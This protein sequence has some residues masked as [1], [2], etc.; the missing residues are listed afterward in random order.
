M[1]DVLDPRRAHS[2]FR[3]NCHMKDVLTA[4][5]SLGTL[6]QDPVRSVVC[7]HDAQMLDQSISPQN[8][9][10][11]PL[12][13]F[14]SRVRT[15]VCVYMCVCVCKICV[16]T[17]VMCAKYV[18]VCVSVCMYFTCVKRVYGMQF[19]CAKCVR[20]LCVCYMCAV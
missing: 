13:V 9:P 16:C 15:P 4:S 7:F 14:G 6:H 19:A 3:Q 1:Q 2:N 5:N 8:L 12:D 11:L 20:E 17:C 18:C 10:P